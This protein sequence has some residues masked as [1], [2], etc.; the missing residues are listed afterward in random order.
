MAYK[1][2]RKLVQH[3]GRELGVGYVVEASLRAV[4]DRTRV[5]AQLV[6]VQD[7][8][9]VWSANYDRTLHD[10]FS[11]QDEVAQ[12]IALSI[13]IQLTASSQLRLST[14]RPLNPYA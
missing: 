13:R 3:I 8:T 5:S 10:L 4:G 14:A 6:R 9:H 2:N 11:L 12:A 7:Q 1:G